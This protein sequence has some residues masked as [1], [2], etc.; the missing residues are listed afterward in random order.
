MAGIAGYSDGDVLKIVERNYLPA[1]REMEK[2][3][4]DLQKIEAPFIGE[5]LTPKWTMA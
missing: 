1:T 4:A 2:I 3:A 5:G